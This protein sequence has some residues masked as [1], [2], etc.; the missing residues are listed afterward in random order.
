LQS[1]IL[2][3]CPGVPGYLHRSIAFDDVGLESA[4]K[5]L[6]HHCYYHHRD[7]EITDDFVNSLRRNVSD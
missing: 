7:E 5:T 6:Q 2:G 1:F 4:R 3:Y